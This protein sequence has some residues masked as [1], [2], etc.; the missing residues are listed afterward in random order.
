MTD[1]TNTGRVPASF[2]AGYG[3]GFRHGPYD[4]DLMADPA[5]RHGAQAGRTDQID[6]HLRELF[7][8]E[9]AEAGQ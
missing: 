4:E 8:P 3:D 6:D 1:S 9:P 7:G 5:Y 2:V